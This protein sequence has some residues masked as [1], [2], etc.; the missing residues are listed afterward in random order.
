MPRKEHIPTTG[1]TFTAKRH[2]LMRYLTDP[3]TRDLS[4]RAVAK[5]ARV[6]EKMVRNVRREIGYVR[7]VKTPKS[8]RT[9]RGSSSKAKG[10]S[11]QS[12]KRGAP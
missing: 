8:A 5:L 11:G 10:K 6:D 1:D 4:H 12:R 7:P 2:R 3:A 9:V